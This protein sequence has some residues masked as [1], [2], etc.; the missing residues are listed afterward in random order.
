LL[1]AAYPVPD[2]APEPVRS[3]IDGWQNFGSSLQNQNRL[4]LPAKIG[5]DLAQLVNAAF[6][7]VHVREVECDFTNLRAVSIHGERNGA[8]HFFL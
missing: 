6:F 3:A 1:L 2:P 8:F 5:C 4:V 7:P